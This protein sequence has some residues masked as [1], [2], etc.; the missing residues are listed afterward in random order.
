MW[1]RASQ[2]R[3]VLAQ[4]RRSLL[5]VTLRP[6]FAGADADLADAYIQA[7]PWSGFDLREVRT[8]NNRIKV[9]A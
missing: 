2:R 8:R 7:M 3:N 1:F 9:F 5:R 6:D 4:T